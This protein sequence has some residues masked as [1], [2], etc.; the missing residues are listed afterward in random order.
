VHEGKFGGQTLVVRGENGHDR[1]YLLIGPFSDRA[2]KIEINLG[3][4]PPGSDGPPKNAELYLTRQEVRYPGDFKPTFKVSN[5]VVMG[6][7]KLPLTLSRDWT[8]EET[9]KLRQPP[10]EGPKP[11]AHPEVGED[12]A[13]AGDTTGGASFRYAEADKPLLGVEYW[14]GEWDKEPCLARLISVYDAKQPKEGAAQRVSAKPGYAVGGLT[15][16]TKRYV[17]AVRVVFMKIK[18][19]GALDPNDSYTSDWL[20]ADPAGAKETTLSGDGRPVIGLNCKQGAI[21]NALALVL[22][23]TPDK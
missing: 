6:T 13:W 2:G 11:N 19:D 12:A 16:R 20:G 15:V 18:P 9:A 21:L 23:K 14:A 5:S 10:P 8:A 7:A 1:R 22:G 3:I 4:A 17:N